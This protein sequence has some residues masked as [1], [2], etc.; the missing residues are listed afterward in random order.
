MSLPLL[1]EESSNSLHK[2]EL[3]SSKYDIGIVESIGLGMVVRDVLE[4]FEGSELNPER[5]QLMSHPLKSF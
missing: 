3:K 2:L 1:R 5:N 4:P